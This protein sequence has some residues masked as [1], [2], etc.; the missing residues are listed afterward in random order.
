MV[1]GHEDISGVSLFPLF[2][3]NIWYF[4]SRELH[5]IESKS[6]PKSNLVLFTFYLLLIYILLTIRVNVGS[7]KVEY[8]STKKA[9]QKASQPSGTI[10]LTNL[11]S[12]KKFD[13]LT[14]QLD[15]GPD[16]VYLLRADSG[17]ELTCWI[18]GLDSYLKEK[19]V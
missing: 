17:A 7:E 4:F 18:N 10:D 19:S 8:F 5:R 14:F 15:G 1:R 16:G 13:S 11:K 3:H 2:L 6:P 9:S 12:V